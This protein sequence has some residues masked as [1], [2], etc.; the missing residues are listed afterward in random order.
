M[1]IK[2]RIIKE[3]YAVWAHHPHIGYWSYEVTAS[4]QCGLDAKGGQKERE[5]K[6]LY[7]RVF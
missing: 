1:R 6:T 2:K 7:S 3:T 5:N 4:R